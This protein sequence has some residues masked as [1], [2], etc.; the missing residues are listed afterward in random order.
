MPVSYWMPPN[1]W[2]TFWK[3]YLKFRRCEVWPKRFPAAALGACIV[4]AILCPLIFVFIGVHGGDFTPLI[5]VVTLPPYALSGGFLL[6]RFLAK[7]SEV[8]TRPSRIWLL[9]AMSW[10]VIA[11]FLNFVSYTMLLIGLE[12]LGIACIGLLA[13]SGL[14]LPLLLVRQSK[15][16]IRLARLPRRAALGILMAVVGLSVWAAVAYLSAPTSFIGDHS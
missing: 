4:G 15:L 13:A 16:E 7:P 2:S 11:Y 9:E 5:S 8:P 1:G 6:R 3:E 10:I 14:S 12:R